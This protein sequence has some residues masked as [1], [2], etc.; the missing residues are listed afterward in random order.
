MKIKR[1]K[2]NTELQNSYPTGLVD[3]DEVV[4]ATSGIHGRMN[5]SRLAGS[6]LE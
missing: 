6:D 5:R 2:T 1:P 3:G 4:G